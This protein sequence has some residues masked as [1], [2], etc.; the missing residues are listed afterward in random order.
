ML[1]IAIGV[2]VWCLTASVSLA[3][4]RDDL[5]VYMFANSLVNHVSDDPTTNVPYWLQQMAAADDRGLEVEG[6][7]MFLKNLPDELPPTPGWRIDGVER[8]SIARGQGFA[9]AGV[10]TVLLNP[11]NFIQYQAPDAAYEWENPGNVTPLGATL[12]AFDAANLGP[13]GRYMVYEGWADM[14]GFLRN[15]PPRARQLRRYH[16]YNLG[17]NADWYDAYVADLRAARPGDDISLIPVARILSELLTESPLVEMGVEALYSDDAPHGTANLY[18]L[19]AMVSYAALYDAPPP[20]GYTVPEALHPLIR[21]GYPVLRD[22]IWRSV[23]GSDQ[24]LISPPPADLP[25]LAPQPAVAPRLEPMRVAANLPP[26]GARPSGAPALAMGLNGISDWSTQ[27]PFVD[28]MKSAR[29]WIGHKPGQ[30]GGMTF[31]EL[32]DGGHL[33]AQG[34]PLRIPE[35]IE[36]LEALILTDQPE[37]AAHLAGRYVVLYDGQGE[38]AL[39]G[40]ARQQFFEPGRAAFS[41]TPG[42]GL[43]GI[44][45]EATDADD[46][47]RNIRVVREDQLP[48]LEAGV[49]F[50]PDWTRRVEDLRSLRFMDWMATN[51]STQVTWDDRPRPDDMT[52]AWRGVPV[53]AMIALSN[54]IGADPWFTLPH[55][56]D[57]AYV[58]AFAET[59][60][61]GLD[62][63]LHAYVEYSNEVWNF[64][65][66]QAQWAQAQAEARWGQSESG[67]MQFY[68]LRAAQVMDIFSEVFADQSDRLVRVVAVHTGWPGLEEQVLNAPLAWLELRRAPSDSFDA[69]AVSG[70]F[71]HGFGG[72]DNAGQ[73]NTWL[74][75]AEADAVAAGEAEGLRRVA[76]REYVDQNRFAAAFAPAAEA[77]RD[78]SMQELVTELWP[79]HARAARDAGLRLVMYEGGTHAKGE[80]PLT[81]DARLTAFLEAFSYSPEM[82]GLYQELLAT[83]TD[84]GGHL[85]NA[86]VDVAPPSK[87]GSWGALRHLDDANPRWDVLM[88]YNSAAPAVWE[89]RAAD[90]FAGGVLRQAAGGGET[91]TG[92]TRADILLGG[93]G[94]DVL[95]AGGGADHLHGGA[96]RDRAVLPGTP[97]QYE[98]RRDGVRLLASGPDGTVTLAGVELVGFDAAPET[99]LTAE[100][101]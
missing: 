97:D 32:R 17:E 38:L 95:V 39:T 52:Y 53:E 84:A 35:G 5:R 69:Y 21:D 57:D 14:Q 60:K 24:A 88:A 71:G 22:V 33:D 89:T 61:T 80:G 54:Q 70:Y 16:A 67:W 64:I 79:H 40:R 82:A 37:A 23:S 73:L 72:P 100:T 45:V 48:L 4:P 66:P 55:R 85:F 76:L 3:T 27:H 93:A 43:V 30:W 28:L 11:E 7:F 92:T 86:F 62:Q 19:A 81:E 25:E 83:W 10:D 74:D 31:D 6:Q 44:A 63:H 58:R 12:Q 68:G 99:V 94:D 56:A 29:P 47:I 2:F 36:R 91:L 96:G 34:W 50:N 42:E 75:A 20:E 98:M 49:I 8:L 1:R 13:G 41:Y 46:P 51:G 9:E 15:F 18:F 90:A 78:G 87:W 65:F 101:L 26:R 59:V 77:L